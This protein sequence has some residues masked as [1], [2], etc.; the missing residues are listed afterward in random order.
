MH[1]IV[2][3]LFYLLQHEIFIVL[4]C[5]TLKIYKYDDE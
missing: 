2:L 1:K 5:G 3:T 4:G